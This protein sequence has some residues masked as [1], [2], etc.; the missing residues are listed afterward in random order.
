MA[1]K[2]NSERYREWA[3]AVAWG[4]VAYVVHSIGNP[5]L[6][7]QFGWYQN[8]THAWSASA[9]AALVAVAGLELGYRRFG[10]VAFV[11]AM[12]TVGALGWEAVE[13]FG[14]L[15]GFGVPLHFH[16]FNDAAV[17]MVSNAV[18]V[19]FTLLV[20]WVRTGLGTEPPFES[21]S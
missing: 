3:P 18:G 6:Y 13:Y 10:L 5:H 12:T 19:S 16:D 9:L 1:L 8:L 21:G 7:L 11:I 2:V 4:V 20:V 15:D 17:D 14:L